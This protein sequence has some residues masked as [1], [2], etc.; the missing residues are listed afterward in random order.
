M[1][2]S[3]A[4]LAAIALGQAGFPIAA[5]ALDADLATYRWANRPIVVFADSDEDPRL[6]D[7]LDRFLQG[8]A[9]L[10][11]RDNVVL[12]DTDPVALSPLR[13]RFRP[14]GFTVIL[15]GKDGGEKLRANQVLPIATLNATID[16]MPMRRREMRERGQN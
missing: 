5:G 11:A 15:V 16:R 4:L 9:Q 3:A 8:S 12:L 1:T 6:K 14:E 10:E 2:A 13:R 7:Q